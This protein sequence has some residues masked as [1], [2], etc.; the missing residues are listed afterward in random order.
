MR[1]MRSWYVV[2]G[3][4]SADKARAEARN[5][6]KAEALSMAESMA[7]KYPLAFVGQKSAHYAHGVILGG[8]CYGRKSGIIVER[9][10]SN[11]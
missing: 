4:G 7:E 3:A 5:L 10:V 6:T 9:S 8:I 11:A 1:N 2:F